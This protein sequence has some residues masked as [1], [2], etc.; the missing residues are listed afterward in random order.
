MILVQN[1]PQQLSGNN[2]YWC[3]I[4]ICFCLGACSPK[5]RTNNSPK[6]ETGAKA[7]AAK[8]ETKFTDANIT[9]LIPFNLNAAKIK[10]ATKAEVEKSA[11][12]IDFYQGFKMGI[13]S[14][15]A[16]GLNF[17]VKVLDTRD[18]NGQIT[19]F[20]K[21]GEM[22]G[23]DLI[24]GPVF[25]EGQK[26]IT[27]YSIANNI[28]VVSPLAASHPDEFRN[29]NLI[30]IVNNIDLHA[31]KSGDYI[32]SEYDP[33]QTVIV[34]INPKKSADEL[35]GAPIRRYFQQGKGAKYTFQEYSSVFT[36]EMNKVP[37][38][39][40]VILLSSADRQFVVATIDKLVK[41]KN[42]GLQVDLFGHPNWARQNYNTEKL[43]L[44]HTRITSSY[45]IDY[46]SQAV[47]SFIKNYRR[48]YQFEPGEY[49][50]KGFDT[51]FYFGKLMAEHG[52]NFLKYLGSEK[53]KGLHN[54]FVFKK[55]DQLGYINNNLFLLEYKNYSLS[56]VE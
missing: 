51:G 11:M 39:R 10:A 32:I 24:V 47:T 27:N 13:D 30:S 23:S 49:A 7:E 6:K 42:S 35:L 55:D 19:T 28:P 53:Y 21:S 52:Q 44:L 3:L 37:G 16:S 54:S 56:P 4:F 41:M 40:Y 46:K 18:S 1:H 45:V 2:K 34:L 31:A 36:M 50:Y 17:R 5:A 38:K 15:S 8:P 14:A 9:L 25:P 26:F 43:Q 22:S 20:I 48:T 12:A 33:D 29:P